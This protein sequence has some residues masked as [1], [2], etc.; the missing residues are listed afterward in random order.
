MSRNLAAAGEISGNG[1]KVRE[2]WWKNLV[3]GK[4]FIASFMFWAA[5]MFSRLFSSLY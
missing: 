5:E 4:L 1:P 3:G 2:V